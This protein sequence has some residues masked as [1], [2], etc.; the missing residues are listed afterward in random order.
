MGVHDDEC[1]LNGGTRPKKVEKHCY[2]A[3]LATGA[4]AGV[5]PLSSL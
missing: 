3:S 4:D 5:H 1:P 2:K